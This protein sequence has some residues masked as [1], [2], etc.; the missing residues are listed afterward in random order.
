MVEKKKKVAEDGSAEKPFT[1]LPEPE[2]NAKA[3]VLQ[4]VTA[5]LE[6]SQSSC[7]IKTDSKGSKQ[8]EVK[9]YADGVEDAVNRAIEQSEKL[10]RY[11]KN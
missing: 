8:Y 1:H 10:D 5:T 6:R 11:T 9:V 4:P 7:V 2:M 3:P